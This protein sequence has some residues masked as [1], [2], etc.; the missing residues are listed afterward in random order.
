MENSH[1]HICVDL[2]NKKQVLALATFL[3]T[4]AQD[5]E[6]ATAEE[7]PK[8]AAPAKPAAARPAPT[9]VED[10]EAVQDETPAPKPAPKAA[11]PA[12][13]PAA[14]KPA[15]PAFEEL[16]EEAQL[17]E[18]KV[19]VT[20]HTKKGKSADIKTLLSGFGANRASELATSDYQGFYD[21]VARYSAGE[22]VNEI[23]NDLV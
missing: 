3:E 15:A 11:A 7:T 20:K 10:E 5:G 13:K 22:D 17:E 21:A 6:A 4:I 12:P 1:A 8:A 23:V 18:I 14:A 19:Q 9:K 16:D 2:A